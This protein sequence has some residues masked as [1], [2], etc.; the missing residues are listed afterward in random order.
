MTPERVAFDLQAKLYRRLGYQPTISQID[1][2][3]C[4]HGNDWMAY[5][6]DDTRDHCEPVLIENPPQVSWNEVERAMCTAAPVM[7]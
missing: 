2:V 1:F 4:E 7:H 3:R 6:Y 5:I